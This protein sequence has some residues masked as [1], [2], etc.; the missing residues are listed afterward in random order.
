MTAHKHEHPS[1][2]ACGDCYDELLEALKPLNFISD[3]DLAHLYRSRYAKRDDYDYGDDVDWVRL[4]RGASAK[5]EEE[6]A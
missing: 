2:A 1:Y 5:A 6:G 4:V 3:D